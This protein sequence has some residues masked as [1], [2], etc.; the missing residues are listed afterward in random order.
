MPVLR[1]GAK[2][3]EG[4][5]AAEAET[6][7]VEPAAEPHAHGATAAEKITSLAA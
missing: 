1:P 3:D 5:R 7:Y 2:M 6:P 4:P